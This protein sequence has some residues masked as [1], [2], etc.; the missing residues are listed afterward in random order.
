MESSW[1]SQELDPAPVTKKAKLANIKLLSFLLSICTGILGIF[2]ILQFE[3][4]SFI[5]FLVWTG[6]KFQF[7]ISS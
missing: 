7:E 2:D 5:F 6:K 4:S 3:I 1:K